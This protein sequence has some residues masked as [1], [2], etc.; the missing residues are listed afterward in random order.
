MVPP[1]GRRHAAE[2]GLRGRRPAEA[3]RGRA[4]GEGLAGV[5]AVCAGGSPLECGWSKAGPNRRW[6]PGYRRDRLCQKHWC[7]G[8]PVGN[9]ARWMLSQEARNPRGGRLHVRRSSA[10]GRSAQSGP[11]YREMFLK[12]FTCRLVLFAFP[13]DGK[14]IIARC[15]SS[16]RSTSSRRGRPQAWRATTASEV[17][18]FL[19]SQDGN[20]DIAKGI[21][22]AVIVEKGVAGAAPT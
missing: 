9:R 20:R 13:R 12:N 19:R 5:A 22:V 2:H 11:F 14:K 7:G 16:P 6:G 3:A 18:T 8:A 10:C 1:F 4:A 21:G 17:S 15:T